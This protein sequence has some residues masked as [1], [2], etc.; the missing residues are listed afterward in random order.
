[1]HIFS[2]ER[3]LYIEFTKWRSQ[4]IKIILNGDIDILVTEFKVSK[5]RSC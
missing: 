1:M 4:K 2:R 5:Y 3:L